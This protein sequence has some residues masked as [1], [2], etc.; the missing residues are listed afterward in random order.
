L[1]KVKHRRYRKS[2]FPARTFRVD[3]HTDLRI[4]EL[5]DS[6][7]ITRSELIANLV[8]G[9]AY[10]PSDVFTHFT[11]GATVSEVVI[12]TDLHPHVVSELRELWLAGLRNET[13]TPAGAEREIEALRTE[14]ARYRVEAENARL[15]KTRILAATNESI[16][17]WKSLAK[18][19]DADVEELRVKIL[20]LTGA[21]A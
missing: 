1:G 20:A 17:R 11:N 12:R 21:A 4:T 8:N 13:R 10:S 3:E 7:G 15:E 18:L 19:K 2:C 14:R 9:V 6:Q 16:E 5:A